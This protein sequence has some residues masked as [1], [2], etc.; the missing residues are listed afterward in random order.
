MITN[1]YFNREQNVPTHYI[2][3]EARLNALSG[4]VC[5]ACNRLLSEPDMHRKGSHSKV[6]LG[7][8]GHCAGYVNSY[9]TRA[10]REL[11]PVLDIIEEDD[12]MQD[13]LRE[14][15]LSFNQYSE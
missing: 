9:R 13:V 5:A 6:E 15:G 11:D 12:D 4:S 2:P 3:Q 7:L 1:P 10:A 8:C 14:V